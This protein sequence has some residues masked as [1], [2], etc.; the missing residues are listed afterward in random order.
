MHLCICRHRLTRPREVY[1]F[2]LSFSEQLF[3]G[4]VG[5]ANFPP[6]SLHPTSGTTCICSFLDCL[7]L[8]CVKS[9]ALDILFLWI[10][11]RFWSVQSLEG[12]ALEGPFNGLMFRNV[13][14]GVPKW[15]G[16]LAIISAR[17]GSPG[18]PMSS[19]RYSLLFPGCFI[20][21]TTISLWWSCWIVVSYL[22]GSM[23]LQNYWRDFS[24]SASDFL[25]SLLP[26]FFFLSVTQKVLMGSIPWSQM[27]FIS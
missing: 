2:I 15:S 20:P 18:P 6:I 12:S 24:D 10:L 16:E 25:G 11:S 17:S 9:K 13:L 8:Q 21:S 7:V 14:E 26:N 27:G 19:W 1:I 3:L 23:G 5:E 22:P 4:L